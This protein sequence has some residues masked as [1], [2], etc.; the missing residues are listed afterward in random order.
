MSSTQSG[1]GQRNSCIST[2]CNSQRTALGQPLTCTYSPTN[3][4]SESTGSIDFG[5]FDAGLVQPNRRDELIRNPKAES[6]AMAGLDLASYSSSSSAAASSGLYDQLRVT[7]H[8]CSQASLSP[9]AST[10]S[11][12]PR[13]TFRLS[14]SVAAEMVFESCVHACRATQQRLF[15]ESLHFDKQ[16]TNTTLAQLCC[17][18]SFELPEPN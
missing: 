3:F 11:R 4:D 5:G 13:N 9:L 8:A 18:E 16:K 10:L 1:N 12:M 14:S 6:E 7:S 17:S 15:M 2:H